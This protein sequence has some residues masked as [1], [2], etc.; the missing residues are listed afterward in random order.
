MQ[1]KVLN[2][3]SVDISG[4]QMLAL[5]GPS[6]CGKSTIIKLLERFYD[7]TAGDLLLD[8][9]AVNDLNL[10]WLRSQIGLVSQVSQPKPLP[11]LQMLK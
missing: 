10:K 4:G 3:F 9:Y 6:G 8:D 7:P 2:R 11:L 5:V 1:V